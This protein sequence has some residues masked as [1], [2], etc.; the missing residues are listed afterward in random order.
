MAFFVGEE[1]WMK[2]NISPG[3][4]LNPGRLWRAQIQAWEKTPGQSCRETGSRKKTAS[5][6]VEKNSL[7]H[8]GRVQSMLEGL[9]LKPHY[10]ILDIGAGAGTLAIPMA[11]KVRQVTAVDPSTTMCSVL[12][13]YVTARG[14]INI[15][16][17]QRAWEDPDIMDHLEPPYDVVVASLSLGMPDIKD[18]IE[19]METVA[20]GDIVLYWHV[21]TPGWEKMPRA[22]W[23]ALFKTSYHGGP[24]SDLLFLVLYE[25]GISPRLD[26]L[27]CRFDMRFASVDAAVNHYAEKFCVT[28]RTLFPVIEGALRNVLIPQ[29]N[30]WIHSID[31]VVMKFQ[32]RAGRRIGM[33]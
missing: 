24:K 32:W 5:G 30:E 6:Y 26:V 18:A 31:H 20:C 28:D 22:L 4:I 9:D 19:K 2:D 14:I 27:T 7:R 8:A 23:P 13:D 10:R 3:G 16:C 12:T 21:G 1:E 33:E 15:S 25:M 17:I 11:G 29:G